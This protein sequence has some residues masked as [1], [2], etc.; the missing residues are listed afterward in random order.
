MTR[1]ELIFETSRGYGL[2]DTAGTDELL[3]QQRWAQRG[4]VDVLE[5]THCFLDIGDMTLTANVSD[6]RI[7]SSILAMDNMHVTSGGQVTE[8]EV[9]DMQDLDEYLASNPVGG[10]AAYAAIEGTLMRLA[11]APTAADVLRYYYVPKPSLMTDDA[12]DPSSATYGGIAT[13]YHDAI[14]YY[15]EWRAAEYNQQGGGFYR[16]KAYAPGSAQQGLYQ[17]RCA[18]IRKAHRKKS[19][20]G[21]H[22][23]RIGYPTRGNIGHRNDQY[24]EYTR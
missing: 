2:D 21:L 22:A 24:P 10:P 8:I 19:G 6:Y 1:G 12:N 9:I 14:L 11:P 20:R 18:E 16:G 13:E 15:M 5:K 7:D 3:L 23:G 17:G 4:V